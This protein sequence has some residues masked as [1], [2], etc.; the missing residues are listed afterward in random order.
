LLLD[1]LG[2]DEA[3]LFT[4]DASGRPEVAVSTR[5]GGAGPLFSDTVV[6][7]VLRTGKSVVLGNALADPAYARSQS[8]V[9]LQLRSVLCCPVLVA[10]RIF[11]LIYLGSSRPAVSYGE[12]DLRD[13][14][15]YALVVGCLANHVGYIEMQG[16]VLASL[17]PGDGPG[18]I[19]ACPPMQAVVKEARAVA[20]GDIA[21]LLQGETGTGKDV[22]AQFIHRSSRRA[23]KPFLALNCSTLRG[24]I[25]ASELFGHKKG[26]FTGALQ[27]QPGIF[28]AADGGTLFLDEIGEMEQP[29]QA[30]LLRTLEAG[31]VRPVGQ[32]AEI[33]VDVRLLCA[34]NRDLEERVASGAFRRD[35]FYRINQHCITL[36]P[37]RERGD[38]VLLLAHW[39]LEKAKRDYPD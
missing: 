6:E 22:L 4:V 39:F 20:A 34:T 25:L 8:V 30:M 1:Q 35:L 29:L 17:G 10:G 18:F 3:L 9:E 37:L 31:M 38:D 33:K 2:G 26:A 5:A 7:K 12:R 36:P 24:E 13:L 32:A 14:E 27:D 21:V 23:A 19:A 16:R 11:G 15:A 28:L